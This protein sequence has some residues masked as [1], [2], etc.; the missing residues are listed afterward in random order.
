ML[1]LSDARNEVAE[2]LAKIVCEQARTHRVSF[3]EWGVCSPCSTACAARKTLADGRLCLALAR[4]FAWTT[5]HERCRAGGSHAHIGR[6]ALDPDSGPADADRSDGSTP[7][8]ARSPSSPG[9]GQNDRC[10]RPPALLAARR[11]SL[12]R[13]DRPPLQLRPCTPRGAAIRTAEGSSRRP[14]SPSDGPPARAQPLVSLLFFQAPS[15]PQ[16]QQ[17]SSSLPS[18]ISR[19]AQPAPAAHGGRDCRLD[20]R[21]LARPPHTP[22]R[23]A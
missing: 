10:S 13:D 6:S 16:Q 5:W 23:N 3:V 9:T 12:L 11:S 1:A 20:S 22:P 4:R 2:Y 19:A 8:R 14:H 21:G 18:R 15:R 17:L 7:A